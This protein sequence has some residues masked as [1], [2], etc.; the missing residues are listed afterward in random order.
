MVN[1]E[2]GEDMGIHFNPCHWIGIK[3]SDLSN[4]A[5]AKDRVATSTSGKA[6]QESK[7]NTIAHA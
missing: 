5:G 6:L 3:E 4:Y 1:W 7:K 2:G